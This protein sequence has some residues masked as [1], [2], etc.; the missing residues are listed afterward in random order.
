MY[1]FWIETDNFLNILR[2]GQRDKS[3]ESGIVPPKAGRLE[4]MYPTESGL[5]FEKENLT[6]S[7]CNPRRRKRAKMSRKPT[8]PTKYFDPSYFSASVGPNEHLVDVAPNEDMH[9]E[10]E[11]GNGIIIRLP[12]LAFQLVMFLTAFIY[13]S[14]VTNFIYIYLLSCQRK[15]N[16]IFI[17][18]TQV[19]S[20]R[21]ENA[22]LKKRIECLQKKEIY[23]NVNYPY[24][25]NL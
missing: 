15:F 17:L 16:L 14:C 19:C 6:N 4:C 3:S 21:D 23:V 9:D 18:R 13:S 24:L 25:N 2:A 1:E 22:K 8:S 5:Q 10:E 7:S 12:L 20:L 11:T